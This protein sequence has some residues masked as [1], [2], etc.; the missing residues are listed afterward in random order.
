MERIGKIHLKKKNDFIKDVNH[1]M[2]HNRNALTKHFKSTYKH[3]PYEKID[4]LIWSTIF[5]EKVHRYSDEV[6]LMSEYLI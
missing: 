5:F 3:N 4:A 6:Y 1:F 2:I